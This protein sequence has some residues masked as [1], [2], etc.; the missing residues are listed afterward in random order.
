MIQV[1]ISTGAIERALS[2]LA[3]RCADTSPV[4]RA[5]GEYMI[6]TTKQRFATATNPDGSPWAANSP[7]T[8][9]LYLA[10]FSSSRTK[11]G[12]LSKAGKARMAAKKPLTGDTRS[13]ATTI[14][15]RLTGRNGVAIGSPME[16][17]A[18]QQFGAGKGAFGR[19]RRGAPIPWGDIPAREFLGFS[20]T[21]REVVLDMIQEHLAG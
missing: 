20:A 10:R 3:K 6:E 16:Y 19:T 8:V 18:V 14:N 21:D 4:M 9:A 12:K 13:L 5:I 11:T 17:S 2:D 1:V 7:V 15:Y